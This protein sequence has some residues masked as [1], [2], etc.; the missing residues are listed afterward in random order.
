MIYHTVKSLPINYNEDLAWCH[1]TTPLFDNYDNAFKTYFKKIKSKNDGLVIVSTLNEFVVND[2]KK[3]V[4][5]SWGP[6]HQYSQNLEKLYTQ[7]EQCLH[8][9]KLTF[10]ITD[11]LSPKILIFIKLVDTNL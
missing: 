4:N 6:W 3:P 1:T 7:Q 2:K 9:K 10:L 8:L 11:M 5:Y